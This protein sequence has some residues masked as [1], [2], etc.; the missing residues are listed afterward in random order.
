MSA[1][2]RAEAERRYPTSTIKEVRL[3]RQAGQRAFVEGAKWAEVDLHELSA[4]IDALKV[5]ED[6]PEVDYI[7]YN[8]AI[9]DARRAIIAYFA[10]TKRSD[11]RDE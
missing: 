6:S 1:E 2:A 4:A 5:D 11:A 7:T 3:I 8:G 10:S 9:D